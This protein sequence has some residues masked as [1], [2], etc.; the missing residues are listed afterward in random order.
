MRICT[1]ISVWI[2]FAFLAVYGVDG[3]RSILNPNTICQHAKRNIKGKLGAICNN[4]QLYNEI[5][6]GIEL[7]LNEC[8]TLFKYRRWNCTNLRKSMKKILMKDTKETGFLYAITSAGVTYSVTK[9]C[10]M[11]TLIDCSC[12]KSHSNKKH[13]AIQSKSKANNNKLLIWHNNDSNPNKSNINYLKTYQAV[14]QEQIF[15]NNNNNDESEQQTTQKNQKAGNKNS[16]W[17]WSGCDDNVN[18]GYIK[19][20]DFFDT[21]MKK[22]SDLKSLIR[23]HNSEVGRLTVKAHMRPE[24]KCH[25]LS[26]SCITKTCW[27]KLVPFYEVGNTLLANFDRAFKVIASN[28]GIGLKLVDQRKQPHSIKK[29]LIYSEPSPDFCKS[30]NSIGSLGTKGR[31]CDHQWDHEKCNALCCD[32]GFIRERVRVETS[33]NCVFKWCCEVKCDKCTEE[34]EIRKCN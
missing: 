28:D 14:D 1:K 30:D 13:Y 16:E 9:S 31:E 19:S 20:R 22:R 5:K 2:I 26:G 18:Y 27:M 21:R 10:S 24:C 23:L 25:G 33:C 6:R 12:D 34:K 8:E 7:G 15:N 29:R 4:Q 3:L 11:G 32:R 17:E